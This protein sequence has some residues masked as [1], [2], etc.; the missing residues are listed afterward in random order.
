M[1]IKY[2][3]PHCATSLKYCWEN[4]IKGDRIAGQCSTD[5]EDDTCVYIFVGK[6]ERRYHFEDVCVNSKVIFK[7]ILRN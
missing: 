3:A 2:E 1:S 4:E 5:R 7:R 6:S